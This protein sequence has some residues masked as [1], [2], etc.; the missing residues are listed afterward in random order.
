MPVSGPSK[1]ILALENYVKAVP[2]DRAGT[3][4][5][6]TFSAVGVAA[7][8]DVFEITAGAAATVFIREVRIGQY[9]DAGD[10]AAEM[11]SLLIVKGYT[12]SGS[13]GSAVTP[14][15]IDGHGA[16]AVSAVEANN[17]TVANTGTALTL[18]ADS[19]NV[20]AGFLYQP[21]PS[22]RIRLAAGERLVV[23]ITAPVDSLTTNGTLIFEEIV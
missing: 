18:I 3:V 15:P 14:A 1:N 10:A 22:D 7:A 23:R 6:A 9:S 19:F 21:N 5:S 12:V 17:T 13:G 4:Y 2:F 11:L 16:V 8:Q 20:Q